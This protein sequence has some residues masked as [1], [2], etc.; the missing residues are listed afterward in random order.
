MSD[1]DMIAAI[2]ASIQ[3]DANLIVLLKSMIAQGLNQGLQPT[4][5]LQMMCSILGIP[6]T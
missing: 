6:T 5:K 3:T 4:A 2:I 1:A